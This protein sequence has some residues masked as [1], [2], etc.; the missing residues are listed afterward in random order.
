MRI[1]I[2]L[3]VLALAVP[4]SAG[5]V[6]GGFESGL[7]GWTTTNVMIDPSTNLPSPRN[8]EGEHRAGDSNCDSRSGGG[9]QTVWCGHD[10][11]EPDWDCVLT[12]GLAGGGPATN[13]YVR[14]TGECGTQEVTWPGGIFNWSMFEL[15]LPG[16]CE[17]EVT[18]EFGMTGNAAW[19]AA[20]YHIDALELVCVVPEPRSGL[21]LFSLVGLPLLRLRRR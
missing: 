20:G 14:L 15:V 4:A 21:L 19:G 13:Y 1:F 16:C 8:L 6:N 7:D 10:P 2:G 3:V 5:L 12:G 11:P 17:S 18:V 9:Y